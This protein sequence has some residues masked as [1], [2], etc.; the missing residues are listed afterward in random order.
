MSLNGLLWR[1]LLTSG[2]LV[3][4][5][6]LAWL[7]L[8]G[9][10]INM[11]VVLPA[12]TARRMA[13]QVV[14]S[15]EQAGAFDPALIPHYYRWARLSADGAVLEGDLD[16]RRLAE[17]RSGDTGPHG[18][19]GYE[20][21]E[22]ALRDGT[23]CV[24]AMNY[25]VPY[26]RASWQ[27]RLPDFQVS[28]LLMLAALIA[29]ALV[30]RTRR[31]AR[32]LKRDAAAIEAASQAIAA[33]RLDVPLRQRAQVRELDAALRTMD[34]LRA[35]LATSL[36]E[37]WAQEQRRSEAV[38]ALAHDLKTPLTVIG[39]NA[40][41]LAEDALTDGQRAG[42]E[43][44]LRG[45]RSAQTYVERLREMTIGEWKR[46]D[47]REVALAD[48]VECCR[49][50]G[51]GICR[52]KHIRLSV[53]MDVAD[54]QAVPEKAEAEREAASQAGS[55]AQEQAAIRNRNT[56]DVQPE[57]EAQDERRQPCRTAADGTTE[58]RANR[59]AMIDV[60]EAELLR[61]VTNLLDNAARFTPAGGHMALSARLAAGMLTLTV[62]DSGT[63]FSAEALARA[64]SA[65]YTSESE[66]PRDG[67][68]GMGLYFVRRVAQSHGGEL[69]LGNAPDGAV[70]TISIPAGRAKG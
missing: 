11:N 8:F 1:Y 5:I 64:G 22:A 3:A 28:Y 60:D 24:L 9:V 16:E 58:Q 7:M 6:A 26:A 37:Q 70:A 25:S 33:K 17:Y 39:G 55:P 36:R 35:G 4:A 57:R 46:P 54:G 68:M 42:V 52:P 53:T 38:A 47:R 34:A 40:E 48:F 13:D 44:I 62:R 31:Y 51:E 56:G 59:P 67:H 65:L 43:A 49:E 50:A 21:E 18:W 27:E 61:A 32:I 19:Y 12:N 66:R 2:A 69:T 15:L 30:L 20:Y 29:T 41:L 23:I 10:L 63:G 14:Q 45:C